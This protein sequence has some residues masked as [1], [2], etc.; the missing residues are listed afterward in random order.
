[1]KAKD[2]GIRD[3]QISMAMTKYVMDILTIIS[4][5]KIAT[6]GIPFVRSI[7]EPNLGAEDLEKW[8]K[9]WTYFNNYWIS[10]MD[11]V[12]TWNIHD[13]DENYFDLVNRTNNDL[14]R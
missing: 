12:A 11:F 3:E 8:G 14:E 6:K 5:G 1:M 7:L 9:F 10:S 2:I 4:R 13:E